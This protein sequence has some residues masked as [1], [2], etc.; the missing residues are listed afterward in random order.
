MKARP[1]KGVQ[2]PDVTKMKRTDEITREQLVALLAQG[3]PDQRAARN[4]MSS[5]VTYAVKTGKLRGRREKRVQLFPLGNVGCWAHEEC[6]GRFGDLERFRWPCDVVV[7]NLQVGDEIR[8]AVLPNTVA[9]CHEVIWSMES[10]IREP[11]LKSAT[12]RQ[13]GTV[14]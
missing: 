1:F 2:T 10:R 5:K 13:A 14:A 8:G 7:D 9:R 4:R 6:R 12:K 11:K 3:V